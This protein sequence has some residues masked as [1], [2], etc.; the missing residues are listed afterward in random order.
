MSSGRTALG[1][2]GFGAFGQ[3]I[4]RYTLPYFRLY[5][6]D[7]AQGL[8]ATA[9]RH[10][11]A[12][13]SLELAASCP[14]VVLAT[15][16]GRIEEAVAAMAPHVRPGSLVLDVASVKVGPAEIMRRGLPAHAG[17]VATHRCSA[18]RAPATASPG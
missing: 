16:V 14:V 12:L 15:P 4:A 1:I 7:P 9:D 17:I 6:Y 18:R 13:T 2:I 10:G 11:V 5:A 8:Q 3:L